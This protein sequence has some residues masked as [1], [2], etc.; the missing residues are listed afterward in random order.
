MTDLVALR[1]AL[2]QRL[3]DLRQSIDSTADSRK[4]VELDQ[5]SVGRLSRMDAVQMQAMA[6]A[7]ERMRG[8]EIERIKATLK[9][10]DDGDFGYCIACGEEIAPKQLAIDPTIPTCIRCASGADR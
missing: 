10:I 1:Q 9:R 6:Q 4:P 2:K 3:D 8:R 5:A 7:A